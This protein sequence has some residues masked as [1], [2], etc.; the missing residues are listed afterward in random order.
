[1]F[2]SGDRE[3]TRFALLALAALTAGNIYA[4]KGPTEGSLY[5]LNERGEAV[6]ICPLKHTDV[7]AKISGYLA[8]VDVTQEFVN[9]GPGKI[10]A[11]YKFPLPPMSAVDDMRMQVGDRT[12]IG[13][14]KPRE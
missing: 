13:K 4:D 10:E 5:K 12:V 2:P 7:Q 3:M 6:D 1:M 11:V 9:P 8:R 14:I